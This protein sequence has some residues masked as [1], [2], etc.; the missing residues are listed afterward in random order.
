MYGTTYWRRLHQVPGV[1]GC[2]RHTILLVSS[3]AS[4]RIK[5]TDVFISAEKIFRQYNDEFHRIPGN[6]GKA[7]L[8]IIEN[9]EWLLTHG[10]EYFWG[11]QTTYHAL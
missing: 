10:T 7:T 6:W 1:I 3:T 2:L 11:E 5:A 4:A 8:H 9:T